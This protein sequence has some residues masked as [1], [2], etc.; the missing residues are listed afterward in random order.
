MQKQ[1]LLFGTIIIILF[2]TVTQKQYAQPLQEE[3][4]YLW[5]EEIEGEKALDWVR[6]ENKRSKEIFTKSAQYEPLKQKILN[7]LNDDEKIA[8]PSITGEYVYNLWRDANNERG[9]WRRMLFTDYIAGKTEWETVLDIDKLS[10]KEG[11]KW[12]Y[13]GAAW[14]E[15]N[16]KK[17]LL[18]LS[19]GG[20]DENVIREFNAETKTFIEDGFYF[21]SSKGGA[22]WIDENT[23]LVNR[24][25][26]EGSLTQSGYS[27]LV[28]VLK[29]GQSV[30][31]AKQV[32][33]TD[34]TSVGAFASTFY[35]NDKLHQFIF[36]AKSFYDGDS[37][38]F[39]D[40]E[41]QKLNYPSDAD[42]KNYHKGEIIIALQSDWEVNE[43]VFKQGA[44]VSFNIEQNLKGKVAPQLIYQPNDKS[45]IASVSQTKDYIVVNVLENVQNKLL[46]YQLTN[47]NWAK[48]NVEPLGLGSIFLQSS[49]DKANHVFLTYSNF[50]T[51]TT[52]YLYNTELN[53]F[54]VVDKQKENFDATGLTI[55]QYFAKSKDGTEIPYFI[56]HQQNMEFDGNNA[57]MIDAYGGFNVSLQP[58]YSSITGAGWLEQG[59]G[60]VL[61]NIRGGGEYGPTWHQSAKKENRQRAYDDA[62]AVAE[63]LIERKITSPK[64]LGIYGWS[65]GGL[66]TGVLFTQR[67]DLY[68]AV[69]VG[70]PLLD[71]KRFS[72]LL[73]GA[74]WMA[75]YGDPDKPED[76]AYIKQYSPYH[77]LKEEAKYP[78]VFFVTSTKDDR[79]HPGHARKMAAKMKGMDYPYLY[80]ETIEGG[81]GAASTNEQVAA[82]WASIYTY[83]NMKLMEK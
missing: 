4:P 22:N 34:T 36:D 53:E 33:E 11:K 71:M 76:W 47:G 18:V 8:Y 24:N 44:L 81:H 83:Y 41:F 20:T 16:Y 63:D 2:M 3:D 51:P 21:E 70:A 14:L 28:K 48:Q 78:E 13:S 79:V 67:P 52:L 26:G 57:V 40:G 66:L 9:L 17:C 80:H 68:N 7:I 74:S 30:A 75:E 6:G 58:N 29:R 43:T 62:I 65:N 69:V 25:F 37:Y 12:V 23:V 55:N 61:A 82:M 19:D 1:V 5:L 50:I 64:H 49:S 60:Y 46:K 73:A 77:N 42:F 38:Y 31:E 35:S 39:M 72:K 45:S 59:G 10:E 56:V 54:K 15:P 32:F 27:R